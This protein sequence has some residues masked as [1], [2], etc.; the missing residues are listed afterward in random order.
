V[1]TPLTAGGLRAAAHEAGRKV[2]PSDLLGW[3]AAAGLAILLLAAAAFVAE[4]A[5]EVL[6]GPGDPFTVSRERHALV[7]VDTDRPGTGEIWVQRYQA[8]VW[9]RDGCAG[10]YERVRIDL[11]G[12]PPAGPA[13]V[14][15]RDS[16]PARAP[17]ED[18]SR[19]A[20]FDRWLP[21]GRWP[22]VGWDFPVEWG[23]RGTIELS[24]YGACSNGWHGR[25]QVYVV[26]FDWRDG[27]PPPGTTRVELGGR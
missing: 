1:H 9:A 18:P 12:D 22:A 19:G 4:H 2:V 14:V 3:C 27:P 15:G 26:R 16:G 24:F 25:H 7:L 11:G 5:G 21:P 8:D 10:R 13:L 17:M 20:F 23:K 6:L